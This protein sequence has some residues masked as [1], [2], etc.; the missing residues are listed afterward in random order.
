MTYSQ[1]SRILAILAEDVDENEP[2]PVKF[3]DPISPFRSPTSPGLRPG[4]HDKKLPNEPNSPKVKNKH[5]LRLI[6][7]LRNE[8]PDIAV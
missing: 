3:G 4:R 2:K 7:E 5:K 8:Q 1:Y 6:K